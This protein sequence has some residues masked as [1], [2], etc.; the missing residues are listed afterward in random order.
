MCQGCECE[1]VCFTSLID[2]ARLFRDFRTHF[3]DG[4]R[5]QAPLL[6]ML[7]GGISG[8]LGP[9]FVSLTLSSS[10]SLSFS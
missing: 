10:S 1:C 5:R 7:M 4:G 9:H 2:P 6:R 3:F 8:R